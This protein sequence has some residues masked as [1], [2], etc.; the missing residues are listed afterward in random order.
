MPELT[1]KVRLVTKNVTV[2]L[3]QTG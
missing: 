1:K 2:H 3:N